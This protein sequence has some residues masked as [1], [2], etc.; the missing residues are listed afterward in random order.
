[1]RALS[2]ISRLGGPVGQAMLTYRG[3]REKAKTDAAHGNCE[4]K[5]GQDP[6]VREDGMVP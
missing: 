1:M 3:M 5:T 2:K 6:L 4:H